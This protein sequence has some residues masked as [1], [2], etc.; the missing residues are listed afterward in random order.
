[1]RSRKSKRVV[2]GGLLMCGLS[3]GLARPAMAAYE[4]PTP[5]PVPTNVQA[6]DAVKQY[7]IMVI[8]GAVD[9]S[10]HLRTHGDAY[11]ALV[12]QYGSTTAAAKAQP[13]QVA[14]LIH[15]MRN[16][17][18]G[19]HNYGYE[20][21]EGI[22]AGVPALIKY[23]IELDS[24]VP[25]KGAGVQDQVAPITIKTGNETIDREG[26]LNSYLIE[27]CVY[28][29]NPHFT[30]GSAVLPGSDQPVRLPKPELVLA[31]ADYSID[32]YSRLLRDTKAWQPSD[33]DFF[34][35]MVLMTPTLSDYFDD[36]KE[37]KQFGSATGGRFAALPRVSD[38]QGILG[39]T[40]LTWLS[41]HDK[42]D[43][44]DPALAA[45]ISQGYDQ[46]MKFIATIY[47][48]ERKHPLEIQTIDA[49]GAQG[50]EKADRLTVQV[51]QAAAELGIDVNGK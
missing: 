23:D 40:R 30:D 35:A 45:K 42:V 51:A 25:I 22:V 38:M 13:Q 17:F 41:M 8:Q 49:L 15:E 34:E 27:A 37:S 12:Q 2:V 14:D 7:M 50:K 1:M 21:V 39:S 18:K 33:R 36:W 9:A 26:S 28:G 19:I 29:T 48:R 43:V 31:F 32:G 3:V 24:G 47:A 46:I 6:K 10:H 20:Y 16:D 5:P 4:E 11:A 44:K